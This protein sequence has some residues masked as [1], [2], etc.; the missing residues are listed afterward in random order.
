M[1]LVWFLPQGVGNQE[2]ELKSRAFRVCRS[3]MNGK[4][5][6]RSSTQIYVTFL[7]NK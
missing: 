7:A 2:Q 6:A 5:P 1:T 4:I 3:Q